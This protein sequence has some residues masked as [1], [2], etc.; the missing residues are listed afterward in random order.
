MTQQIT[1]TVFQGVSLGILAGI[2]MHSMKMIEKS[3]NH[4]IRRNKKY[5]KGDVFN[6]W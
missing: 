6:Y 1:D 4:N 2:S 5:K 3:M